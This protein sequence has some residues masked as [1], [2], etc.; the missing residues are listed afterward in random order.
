MNCREARRFLDAHVDGELDV[1]STLALEDHV[2]ACSRC[3]AAEAN[4]RTLRSTLRRHT[5]VQAVPGSLGVLL[6]AKYAD[7]AVSGAARTRLPLAFALSGFAALVL[8]V[9]AWTLQGAFNPAA[10]GASRS[11][12]KV[13]YHISSSQTAAAALRTLRNHLDAS[14]GTKVVVV[15]HNE[16]V[17]FLLRGARDESGQLFATTVRQF[18]QRGVDFRVCNNTLV[19]RKIDSGGILPEATLVPSGIAEIGRLQDREGYAYMRM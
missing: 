19:R 2:R 15:A 10:T 7:A 5:E 3:R 13:V 11:A 8:A 4:A 16:G 1:S 9:A 17:D 14:P 18:K 12:G 6:R